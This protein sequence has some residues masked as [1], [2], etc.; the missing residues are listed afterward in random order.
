MDYP[1]IAFPAHAYYL[2]LDTLFDLDADTR[3][4]APCQRALH[5]VLAGLPEL[6]IA[7]MTDLPF[8]L[9]FPSLDVL[10]SVIDLLAETD[11]ALTTTDVTPGFGLRETVHEPQTID[12]SYRA[13][14]GSRSRVRLSLTPRPGSGTVRFRSE[15]A[16]ASVSR[17]TLNLLYQRVGMLAAHGPQ[18]YPLIDLDIA[19]VEASV[20]PV[21][22][23]VPVPTSPPPTAQKPDNPLFRAMDWIFDRID[24]LFAGGS[25]SDFRDMTPDRPSS[26]VREGLWYAAGDAMR[27]GLRGQTALVEP[28]VAVRLR[29]PVEARQ[30]VGTDFSA[31]GGQIDDEV[32]DGTTWTINGQAPASALLD[33]NEAL[34]ELAGPNASLEA[35]GTVAVR[36]AQRDD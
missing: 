35:T 26:T 34:R 17:E 10:D 33:Y 7:P 14:D 21:G 22:G 6:G 3:A 36:P 18:G 29:F 5:E 28:V 15:M 30:A 20:E 24:A 13:K 4:G 9:G 12:G 25:G 2:S 19:L 27:Y 16:F 8:V 11:C 31:R 32:H 23:S 1:P